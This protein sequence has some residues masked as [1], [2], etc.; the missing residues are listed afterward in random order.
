MAKVTENVA[1][2]L[3]F[4]EESRVGNV[5]RA[6]LRAELIDAVIV[7]DDGSRDKSVSSVN[8]AI[9][10]EPDT[11]KEFSLV[12]H[13]YNMG[14]TETLMTGVKHAKELGGT[15]LSTLVFLDADSSPIW[16]RDT[17]DNMKLWQLAVHSLSGTLRE[18]LSPETSQGREEAFITLLARYIDEIVEPVQS[19]K[20]ILR[21]GMYQ[22]NV[23]TDTLLTLVGW[24]GHA[25]NR[26]MPLELWEGMLKEIEARGEHLGEWEIEGAINAYSKNQDGKQGIFMMHGVVNVGSRVKAGGMLAGIKRMSRIHHQAINGTAKLR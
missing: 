26:A 13:S 22:R 24:G 17:K 25:G 20:E 5:V 8:M 21:S 2:I 12:S 23:L 14:K 16:S 19:G 15:A 11:D 7:V 18:P 10:T 6:S 1:I 4:N 3:T 9:E